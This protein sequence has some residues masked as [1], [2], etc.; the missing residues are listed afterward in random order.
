MRH[1]AV[2]RIVI[3]PFLYFSNVYEFFD[4][5]PDISDGFHSYFNPEDFDPMEKY[6]E[7]CEHFGFDILHELVNP[8]DF[9]NMDRPDENWEVTR[10]EQGDNDS[11]RGI[12]SYRTPGGKLQQSYNVRRTTPYLV[13]DATDEYLVKSHEDFELIHQYGPNPSH[14]NCSF[15]HKAKAAVRDK[16][17]VV[18]TIKGAF[19]TL[20]TIRKQE[21]VMMDPLVDE[22]F[23][24]EMM[25][26][27]TDWSI[28]RARAMIEAG[29][30]GIEMGAN[31]GGSAV[32]PQFFSQYVLPY[33]KRLIAEIHQSGGFVIYHNCGAAARVMH[34]YNDLDTDVWGYLTPPPFGDVNLEEALKTMKPDMVLRGN[35]DQIEFLMKATPCE[36]SERVR[37]LLLRVKPRGNFILSTTDFFSNGTPR[38]NIE[39]FVAAGREFG[40]YE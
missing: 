6:V 20:N 36:V 26:F 4:Y 5:R 25:E 24:R 30:D 18:G 39:A 10:T 19:N 1:E 15:V 38:A 9:Y 17:L 22:A 29:A 14:I 2:D 23:Y 33:E 8:W 32:G 11:R 7:Y 37:D 16:G 34:L 3:A 40:S 12:L 13:I 27:C 21:A 31:I 28:A 35:I